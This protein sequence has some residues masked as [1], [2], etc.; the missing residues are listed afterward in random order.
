[1]MNVIRFLPGAN[2]LQ[3]ALQPLIPQHQALQ[4]VYCLHEHG[5]CSMDDPS[6][7]LKQA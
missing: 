1:M 3:H 2:V 4:L 5:L 7:C 6:M